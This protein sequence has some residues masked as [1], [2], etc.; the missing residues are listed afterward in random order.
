ML[1]NVFHTVDFLFLWRDYILKSTMVK[2]KRWIKGQPLI[3]IES[4]E[5]YK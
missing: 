5:K 4:L 2:Q 1:H 3:K